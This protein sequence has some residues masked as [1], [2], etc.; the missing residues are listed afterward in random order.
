MSIFSCSIKW[1]LKLIKNGAFSRVAFDT[2]FMRFGKN[3]L[4]NIQNKRDLLT[5]THI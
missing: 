4:I 3:V 1:E 2:L 5:K